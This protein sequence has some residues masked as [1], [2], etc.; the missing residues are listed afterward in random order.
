ML[1]DV[2]WSRPVRPVFMP[3]VLMGKRTAHERNQIG[4]S[5]LAMRCRKR[6]KT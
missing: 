3:T 6:I 5:A 4:M 2:N 1:P